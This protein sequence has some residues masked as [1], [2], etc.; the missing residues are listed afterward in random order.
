MNYMFYDESRQRAAEI[1]RLLKKEKLLKVLNYLVRA[2]NLALF[3]VVY[4]IFTGTLTYEMVIEIFKQ[5]WRAFTW[6][7]YCMLIVAVIVIFIILPALN[8]RE[9]ES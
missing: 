9:D 2:M 3:A 5:D 4:M 1:R 8:D 6:V 7:L